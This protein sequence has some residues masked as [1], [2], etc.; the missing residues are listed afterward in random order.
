LRTALE[1]TQREFTAAH[2]AEQQARAAVEDIEERLQTAGDEFRAQRDALVSGG[3]APPPVTSNLA[4]D[5][6]GLREWSVAQRPIQQERETSVTK[7]AVELAAITRDLIDRLARASADAGVT[8]PRRGEVT[9]ASLREAAA[10]SEAHAKHELDRVVKGRKMATR[11]AKEIVTTRDE[12]AVAEELARLLR[13]N[14]FEQWLVNEAL[15]RLVIAASDTLETLSSN[16]Y[17]LAVNDKNEFE[18]IDHRNADERRSVRTLSGGETFQASLAL[19]LAL[20]EQLSEL[21][22]QGTAKLDAIFLDEGFGTLDP[23]SLDT[24]AATLETLGGDTRM[25][26]LITH[27]RELAER[28]PTRFEVTKG[29]RTSEVIR[30]DA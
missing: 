2:K 25:V 14:N 4:A 3:L 18:V 10:E 6:D 26:G 30:M 20:A 9:I 24:V 13:A 19:A 22:T 21:A 16:Q 8:L 28:V 5:W 12:V 1:K 15:E 17:A 27:V 11:L 29:P 7:R 23:D